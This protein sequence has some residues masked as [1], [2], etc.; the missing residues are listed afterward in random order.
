VERLL[1]QARELVFE[2]LTKKMQAEL[3][4]EKEGKHKKALPQ[5]HRGHRGGTE[6]VKRD[7]KKRGK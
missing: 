1:R 6:K 5:R 3:M 2:K 4:G 7:R